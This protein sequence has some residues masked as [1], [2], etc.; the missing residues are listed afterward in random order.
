MRLLVATRNSGKLKEIS[1]LLHGLPLQFVSLREAGI[2]SD[3][4][5]SGDTFRDNAIL[6]ACGYARLSRLTTLA[7]DSGLEVAALGGAPGVQSAR[8]AGPHATDRERIELLLE[9]LH[10]VPLAQRQAQFRTVVAIATADLRVFTVEGICHGLITDQ[11][12][13]G[14]G[15]GYDPVFLLPELGQT[16]AELPLET[17]NRISHRARAVRAAIPILERLLKEERGGETCG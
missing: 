8:W 14:Y 10:G 17:K 5:E 6:K 16:M 7:D 2:T 15:F 11:P 12:R 9:R 13:G 3:I 4:P 1:K